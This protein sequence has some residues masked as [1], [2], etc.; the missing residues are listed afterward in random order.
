MA[1]IILV[2]GGCRSGKSS[3]A[4]ELAEKKAEKRLFIASCPRIDGELDERIAL[5]IRQRGGRGWQT[6]EEELELA[7]V[8]EEN[9]E[10]DVILVDCLTLWVNNLL[11]KETDPGSFDAKMMG[12]HCRVLAESAKKNPGSVIFVTN[13][14]GMGIV[15]ENSLARLY[16]DLVGSCNQFMAKEANQVFLVSCG[17]PLQLK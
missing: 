16:R 15:P 5:H 7:E 14:V 10:Y 4:L 11:F 13:E 2:T 9:N 1:E 6:I 12:V 3:F 8:I 17:I